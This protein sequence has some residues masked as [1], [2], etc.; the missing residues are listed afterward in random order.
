MQEELPA[1]LTLMVAYLGGKG[2][3]LMQAFLPNTQ[4][5]GSI[6]CPTGPSG[7]VDVTSNGTSL[8]N[9]LQ[10][11]LRRRLY[12][13]FTASVQYTLRSP[14]TMRRRSAT[15]G[16]TP[17]SLAIAQNWLDLGAE[18]GPSSFDQRHHVTAQIQYSTGRASRAAR[19]SMGSG[20]RSGRTGRSRV[21]SAPARASAARRSRFLADRGHRAS[22]ASVR[23]SDGRAAP[24]RRR[25][26]PS[27]IRP[28][29]PRR[30]RHLGRRGSQLAPRARRSSRWT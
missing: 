5:P 22:S 17:A 4:P 23:R 6:A 11:T 21:N 15:R 20:D 25:R 19:C 27:R 9:A 30:A 26:A 10:F 29:I 12:A 7:F 24:S 16:I 3:H 1:S 13:G 8:R 2:S 14:R 28:P 18:R